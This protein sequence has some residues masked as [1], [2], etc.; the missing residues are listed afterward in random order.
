MRKTSLF[1]I[2]LTGCFGVVNSYAIEEDRLSESRMV[3]KQFAS[4]LK[5]ELIVNL[6]EG[7]PINAISVCSEKASMIADRISQE[8][9]WKIGRVSLRL[10]NP[11]NAPDAWERKALEAF[12]E[13]S[14]KGADIK[15]LEYHETLKEGGKQVFRYMKAIPVGEPCLT[16]HGK[17]IEPELKAKLKE[18]Y[19][20]D[21]AIDFSIG[22]IIGAFSIS[23]SK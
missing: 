12:E 17:Q 20:G 22:E 13:G 23:Q 2:F 1:I 8:K 3:I 21:R 4:E 6:K 11:G 16:C 9:G 19:P 10:R 7:G 14:M 18:V 15:T 5:G